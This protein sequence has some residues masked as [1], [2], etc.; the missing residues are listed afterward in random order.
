MVLEGLRKTPSENHSFSPWQSVGD[1][2]TALLFIIILFLV[3][4]A[5][6]NLIEKKRLKSDIEGFF[7][8]KQEIVVELKKMQNHLASKGILVCLNENSGIV[9]IPTPSLFKSEKY[10]PDFKRAFHRINSKEV[11]PSGQG[12]DLSVSSVEK[13]PENFMDSFLKKY[14]NIVWN[15][16]FVDYISEIQIMGYTDSDPISRNNQ[17]SHA[18]LNKYSKYDLVF[19]DLE[20]KYGEDSKSVHILAQTLVDQDGG[21]PRDRR[22]QLGNI[23]LSWKRAQIIYNFAWNRIKNNSQWQL[24]TE[25]RKEWIKGLENKVT[26]SG[27]GPTHPIR[28][29]DGTEDKALSRRVE[30][31]FRV[32][33]RNSIKR[34]LEEH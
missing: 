12:P 29:N 16:R 20:Y 14:F 30:F 13:N 27:L 7:K 4:I 11:C 15:K 33:D 9:S 28:R 26:T 32:D 3:V 23:C 31:R 2:M 5:L 34:I 10:I 1:I 21:I 17:E 19:G 8:K 18:C 22:K 6:K 25:K 24:T